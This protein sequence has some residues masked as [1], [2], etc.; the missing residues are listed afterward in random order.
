[1]TTGLA[2]QDLQIYLAY[3]RTCV[4][5][6]VVHLSHELL[7]CMTNSMFH[8]PTKQSSIF[9]LF[10]CS[11]SGSGPLIM[12]LDFAGLVHCAMPWAYDAMTS[13]YCHWLVYLINHID[14]CNQF[15]WRNRLVLQDTPTP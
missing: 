9:A 2:G 8:Y 5:V 4:R 6:Y 7:A 14:S 12:P 11:Q 1:M 10:C 3:V 13:V 15:H